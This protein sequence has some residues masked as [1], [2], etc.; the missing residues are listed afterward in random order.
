MALLP[1]TGRCWFGAG[2]LSWRGFHAINRYP[3]DSLLRRVFLC[4]REPRR[5]G[6]PHGQLFNELNKSCCAVTE[7]WP[8]LS[9]SQNVVL[10]FRSPFSSHAPPPFVSAAVLKRYELTL[11]PVVVPPA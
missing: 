1:G 5:D 7:E 4:S 9:E 11:I 2:R 6:E 10:W 8:F 3:E